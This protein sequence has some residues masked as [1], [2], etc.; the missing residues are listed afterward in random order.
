M[1]SSLGPNRPFSSSGQY[2][3]REGGRALITVSMNG[4]GNIVQCEGRRVSMGSQFKEIAT[5]FPRHIGLSQS[6]VNFL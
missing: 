6:G 4:I 2:D 1:K 5:G 3:V